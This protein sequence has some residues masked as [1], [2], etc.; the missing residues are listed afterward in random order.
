M[1]VYRISNSLYSD[2]ISGMGAKLNG[3]RWNSVGTPMLYTAEHIS[4]SILEMLVNTNFKDYNIPLDLLYIQLPDTAAIAEVK[5]NKL[6]SNWREDASFTRFMGDEFIKQQQ[7]LL[8][9]VPSVVVTQEYNYLANPLHPDFKKV[10]IIK[11]ISFWPDKR[12]F[13]L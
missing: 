3:A 13:A 5:L 11:T 1:I 6:K 9:K 8:L 7:S 2:D 4:L 10:K 12:L